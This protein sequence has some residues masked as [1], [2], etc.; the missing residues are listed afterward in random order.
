MQ[1]FPIPALLVGESIELRPLAVNDFEVLYSVA[2]DPLIWAQHPSSTRYQEPV[3]REWFSEALASNSTFVI[4]DRSNG[5]VIGSSRYYQFNEAQHDV[6]IGY[7][8]LSREKWGGR[9]NGELKRMM[10]AYAFQSVDTVWLH[11]GGQNIRSQRAVEKLG[12]RLSHTSTQSSAGVPEKVSYKIE[13]ATFE[14]G[15]YASN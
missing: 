12:G 9:T 4:Y 5:Q 1:S 11:V 8:F 3:F 14:G 6:A 15:R 10:L 7:T 13:R 2:S